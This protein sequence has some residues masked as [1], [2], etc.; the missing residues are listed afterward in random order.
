MIR[1]NTSHGCLL[2]SIK[3][4]SHSWP[5]STRDACCMDSCFALEAGLAVPESPAWVVQA[6]TG[7]LNPAGLLDPG[8]TVF[9][10]GHVHHAESWTA[11][12]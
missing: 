4:F 5:E 2:H 3:E 7:A 9:R 12:P 1:N 8:R 6:V 10:S 11:A